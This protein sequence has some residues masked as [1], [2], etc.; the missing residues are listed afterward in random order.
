MLEDFKGFYPPCVELMKAIP[1]P[2]I[3]GILYGSSDTLYLITAYFVLDSD[4]PPLPFSI[5][6]RIILTGDA[7]H[8]TTPHQGAGAGQATEDAL[9]LSR[10]L[11]QKNVWSD[12]TSE[13]LRRACELYQEVRHERAAQVQITSAQAGLLY[14]GRGVKGE[15]QDR[16]KVKANLDG[17]MQWIWEYDVEANL[18]AMLEKARTL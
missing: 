6:D 15:G 13:K 18:N 11:G 5:G 10:L 7:A 17:R 12:P 8:G 1:K 14:E 3:W 4:L 9:F 2:S 16:Q